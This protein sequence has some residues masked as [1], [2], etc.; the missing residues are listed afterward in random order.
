MSRLNYVHQN[1]VKHGLVLVAN[2][3]RWC[4]AGWLERTASPAMVK[5]VF[6]FKTD[7]LK[8][9]DDFAPIADA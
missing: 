1:P 9:L 3:Y 6:R 8:V 5:T 4:S 7:R 2:Q